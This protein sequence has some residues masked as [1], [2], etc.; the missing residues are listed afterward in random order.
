MTAMRLCVLTPCRPGGLTPHYALSLGA[1]QESLKDP[2]YWSV[3]ENSG[4]IVHARNLLFANALASECDLALWLDA[5]ASF[6][7]A[8]FHELAD[9]PEA[10]IA[11]AGPMQ[12]RDWDRVSE[13]LKDGGSSSPAAL[14][15]ASL[16]FAVSLERSPSGALLWSQDHTLVRVRRIGFHWVLM[17]VRAMA[18]LAAGLHP[19]GLPRDWKGRPYVAAFDLC[20]EAVTPAAGLEDRLM[21]E[22]YSFCKRWLDWTNAGI[23]CAPRGT[24]RNGDFEGDYIEQLKDAGLVDG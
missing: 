13:H 23:W 10:M 8:L 7:P 19:E 2:I 18:D 24:I 15:R 9:R 22:D 4:Q 21:G 6:G 11:R 20:H 16:R 1:L 14:E 3:L 5:D 17:K 12:L